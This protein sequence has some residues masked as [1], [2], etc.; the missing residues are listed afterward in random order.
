MT[1]FTNLGD[2]VEPEADPDALALI[3]LLDGSRPRRLT[4]GEIDGQ[5]QAVA[6]GL[7]AR[8]HKRGERVAIL[9]ANRSEFITSYF[10]TM[11][12]GLVSVPVSHR[13]PR[14]T[15]QYILRDAEVSMIFADQARLAD[16]P[17]GLPVVCFDD[18]GPGGFECF[19]DPGGFETVHP[20]PG[21]IGMFLYTSGSTGRP[22]GVPLSHAGQLWVIDTRSQYDPD[23]GQHRFL[24]AAPLYHMN[25][26]IFT[27]LAMAHHASMVLLPQFEA[28]AYI[29]AIEHYRCTWL[30][31]VPTMLALVARESALLAGTDLS[32]VE[33]VGTGS[34]PLSQKL[35]DQLKTIFPGRMQS[36]S[37]G[38][39]EAGAGVFG[40]HPGGLERPDLSLGHPLPEIGIRLIGDD[41][42]EG[43][44]GVLQL[45]TPAMMPGY[46]NLPGTTAERI[47][48][49]AWYD[50][51]DVM[52]RDQDGFYYFV[53]RSD[54]MFNC[55][56][57]NIYPGDVEKMLER[58][59]AI[60]Q[61]CVVPIDDD[62]KGAKPVAFIVVR[63]DGGL[64]EAEVKSFALANGPA[65]QHPRR[66]F[67]LDALPLAAT[68]KVDRTM[69][70][71][72][73]ARE[74]SMSGDVGS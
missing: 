57:E 49:D 25:A 4:H 31:S 22:K 8:G 48:E 29:E 51:G 30:T 42:Q 47:T 28:Q 72:R 12:A 9:S 38:T 39:T 33:I 40:P 20:G 73:A 23:Y 54:D 69:L 66:V 70:L 53:G 3:D 36:N 34:A 46:H 37:Y 24:V 74:A 65:F 60:D 64:S 19:L 71:E 45:D 2:L 50:T 62:I 44:E 17:D 15:I 21:E 52:R 56:G 16:C 27:K 26:L 58:H 61:A 14:E 11:R 13:F 5:A 68:N 59:P 41:G 10:G 32:S 55:G 63:G 18:A 7:L 35:V 1:A 67:F 43:D 6:R